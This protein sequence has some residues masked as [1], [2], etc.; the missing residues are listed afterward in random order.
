MRESESV[1]RNRVALW[2]LLLLMPL[3]LVAALQ[4]HSQPNV[5][6]VVQRDPLESL[7]WSYGVLS[8]PLWI[9]SAI[10]SVIHASNRALIGGLV[11]AN[12]L[13]VFAGALVL[14]STANEAANGWF[15]Y[16]LGSPVAIA[17]GVW[18]AHLLAKPKNAA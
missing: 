11:G 17:L 5:Q 9:W 7:F 10:A 1:A 3:L 18:F 12:S 2:G 6:S 14:T 8:A 16:L 15:V 13:L 4:W